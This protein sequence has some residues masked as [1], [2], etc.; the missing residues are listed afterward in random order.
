MTLKVVHI[1]KKK[2]LKKIKKNYPGWQ[3]GAGQQPAAWIS[4]IPLP[5]LLGVRFEN[6]YFAWGW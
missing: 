6:D 2:I 4:S 1:K 3:D 5:G